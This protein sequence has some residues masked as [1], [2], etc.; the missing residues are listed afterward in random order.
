M[1]GG[2]Y[3]E[4]CCEGFIINAN[5]HRFLLPKYFLAL[6]FKWFWSCEGLIIKTLD[7]DA[8]YEPAKRSNNWLKLKKDYMDRLAYF[9]PSW[10]HSSF[11]PAQHGNLDNSYGAQDI[12]CIFI[13]HVIVSSFML[14]HD[15]LLWTFGLSTSFYSRLIWCQ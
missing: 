8:T 12:N 1:G 11:L 5:H 14:W 3:M 2:V 6:R 9:M 13:P 10:F 15:T 7:T 4:L